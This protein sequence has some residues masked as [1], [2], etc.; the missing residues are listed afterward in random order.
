MFCFHI[1]PHKVIMI[2]HTAI[3]LRHHLIGSQQTE[4]LN[5]PS[6]HSARSLRPNNLNCRQIITTHATTTFQPHACLIKTTLTKNQRLYFFPKMISLDRKNYTKDC[7]YT[8]H[9]LIPP[10]TP[11]IPILHKGNAYQNREARKE[12]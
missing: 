2:I 8:W 5:N 3:S 9:N 12:D 6:T 10:T 11:F 4:F 7:N 1:P